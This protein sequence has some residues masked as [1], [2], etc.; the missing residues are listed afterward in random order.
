[1]LADSPAKVNLFYNN[2][3]NMFNNTNAIQTISP[4]QPTHF[5]FANN[6]MLLQSSQ[7]PASKEHNHHS[8]HG[9]SLM[10]LHPMGQQNRNSMVNPFIID[11]GN[12]MDHK[13]PFGQFNL[14]PMRMNAEVSC[15]MENMMFQHSQPSQQ[16]MMNHF[17]N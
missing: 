1:M 7:T 5:N 12:Q 13:E 11:Q 3:M 9:N 15:S 17:N 16:Q 4:D 14:Q 6:P 2:N 10:N 8:Y